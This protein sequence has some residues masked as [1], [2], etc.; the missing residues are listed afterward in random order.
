MKAFD[1]E[2]EFETALAGSLDGDIPEDVRVAIKDGILEEE[3]LLRSGDVELHG[4]NLR[5]GKWLLRDDDI[6]VIEII[7]LVGSGILAIAATGP[8]GLAAVISGVKSFA[9]IVWDAWRKSARLGNNEITMLGVIE[10]FGPIDEA[11]AIAEAQKIDADVKLETWAKSILSLTD[12]ELANGDVVELIRKD[13]S[14]RW[15]TS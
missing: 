8:L 11:D 15:V 2:A 6:P 4:F 14:E 3:R 13:A 12:V 5:L 10:V 7:G 1:T 9:K